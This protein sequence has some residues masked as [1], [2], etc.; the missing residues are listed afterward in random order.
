MKSRQI[1]ARNF[2][3]NHHDAFEAVSDDAVSRA[4]TTHATANTNYARLVVVGVDAGHVRARDD[5][6]R[7]GVHARIHVC[8][9]IQRVAV[10]Q[11]DGQ[12]AIRRVAKR[13]P[14]E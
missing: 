5:E 11:R 14:T 2:I 1:C 13:G 4:S 9:R 3:E 10:N 8:E 7:R 6:E 12:L